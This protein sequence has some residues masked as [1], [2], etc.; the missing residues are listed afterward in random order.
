MG[1]AQGLTYTRWSSSDAFFVVERSRKRE[2]VFPCWVELRGFRPPGSIIRTSIQQAGRRRSQ[3]RTIHCG[4]IMTDPFG[5]DVQ[6][7]GLANNALTDV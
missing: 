5:Y 7:S 1:I 3:H 2:G 4:S 6:I